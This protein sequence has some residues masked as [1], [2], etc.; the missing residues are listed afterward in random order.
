MTTTI[1]MELLTALDA[2]TR[3][4]TSG[5]VCYSYTRHIISQERKTI[6]QTHDLGIIKCFTEF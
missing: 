4:Q 2:S 1:F 6:L 3:V 5:Q